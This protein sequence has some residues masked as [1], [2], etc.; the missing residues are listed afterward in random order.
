MRATR[1]QTSDVRHQTSG[2]A[3]LIAVAVLGVAGLVALR[4]AA[5]GAPRAT[6]P[7]AALGRVPDFSLIDQEGRAFGLQELRGSVWIANFI[8]TRCAGQCPLMSARMEALQ[9]ALQDAPGVRF[10]SFTVD[11][12]HDRPETLLR[13]ARQYA[14]SDRWRFLTG[15]TAAIHGLARDG[16]HLA[17]S[18]EGTPEEPITHSVRLVLVDREGMIRGAYD[19]M[20]PAAVR[21]LEADARGL[22]AAL[23]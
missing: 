8:F 11:P 22:E 14:A 1:H 2:R 20:D 10:V 6:P 12:E 7:P 15:S 23:R 9:Q 4:L 18:E 5:V 21:Q 13:Y 3:A 17:V 19:A 16:F